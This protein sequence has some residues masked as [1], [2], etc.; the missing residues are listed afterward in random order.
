MSDSARIRLDNMQ[1]SLQEADYVLK[2]EEKEEKARKERKRA[3]AMKVQEK[4]ALNDVNF[5][6]K[7]SN[8]ERLKQ[9][10]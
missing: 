5:S 3:L 6:Q 10:K 2:K 8:D 7:T 1:K 4:A 9:Y